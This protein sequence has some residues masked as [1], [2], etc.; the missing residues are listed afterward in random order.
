MQPNAAAVGQTTFLGN[1]ISFLNPKAKS[2]Y[3]LRW[4][5]GFQHSLSPNMV[6]EV[7]Y[8][9][10]HSV[11]TPINLTQLNGI[12]RQ[13][14]STLPV[15]DT[16][17]NTAMSASVANPFLGLVT[18]GTPAGATTTVAQLLAIYPEFP[19]GYTSGGFSGSGGVLEQNLNVGSSY[20]HSLNVRIQTSALRRRDADRQLHLLEADGP[21][22]LAQRHG[23]ASR[24]THR[25][26]RPHASR[27]NHPHLRSAVRQGKAVAI[28]SRWLNRVVGGWQLNAIYTKQSGQPFTWMGTSSTTIG[29]LVYFGDKLNFNPRETNGLAFNTSAFDTRTANQ[30]AYHIRTFSTTFSSLRGDGTNEI[31]ASMLKKIDF[32][33]SG[34]RYFQLRFETFNL[35]NH[36]SF[37]FPQLAPTNSAFGLITSQSNK[38]RSIQLTG[39]IVF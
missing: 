10:N 33:D 16:A 2:P 30:F 18:S 12:P 7:V 26:L 1:T 29:D 4:N 6:L 22:H 38:S 21:D 37:Q 5:F 9:G 34:K 3:S 36:P 17:L 39:R 8:I 25:R 19:L 13:Y 11:H 14:L 24:K 35:L 31:N 15:R 27:R 20:F 28:N 32:T 23:P